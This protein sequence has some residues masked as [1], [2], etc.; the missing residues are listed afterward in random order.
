MVDNVGGATRA[1]TTRELATVLEAMDER[2]RPL[3]DAMSKQARGSK[4]EGENEET[5][6]LQLTIVK[7]E[8]SE[9]YASWT[10]HAETI[11]VSRKLKGYILGTKEKPEEENSKEG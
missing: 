8:G 3:F 11:L 7:L 10:E 5:H 2:Y 6:P 4:P 9:S 1:I